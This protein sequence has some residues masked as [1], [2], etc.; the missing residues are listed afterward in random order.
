MVEKLDLPFPLL[1]DPDRS[2]LIEP[3]GVADPD[4]PREIARPAMILLDPDGDERFRFVS[5]D[6]ADRLPEDDVLDAARDLG[7]GATDQPPPRPGDPEP[8]PRAMPREALL[9][10]F[11]GARYAALALGLRHKDLSDDLKAD[12]KAYVDQMDRFIEVMK[13]LRR[14]LGS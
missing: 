13:D 7:L 9:P 11:R 6:Y 3:A 14:R 8:G 1:S 4:D 5:R 10:Y 2:L 12:T